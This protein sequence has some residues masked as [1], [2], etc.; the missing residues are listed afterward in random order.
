MAITPTDDALLPLVDRIY[1]SVDCPE[2][3][4]ETIAALGAVIGGRRDF[5]HADEGARPPAGLK[6]VEAGCH[7]TF[8]LSRQDLRV[9]DDYAQDFGQLIIR[10]LKVVFLSTLWSQKDVGAREAIGLKITERYLQTFGPTAA[11]VAS[12]AAGSAGRK[13]IAALWEDGRVFGSD[14]LRAMRLLIPH[15][16]RALRLQMRLNA[17]GLRSEMISGALDWL[18]LGVVL[19]D[20][21]GM[22]LWLNRRARQIMDGGHGLHVSAAGFA[23]RTPSDTRDLRA[24]IQ[25]VVSV[26]THGLLAIGRADLRPLLL[27][28]MPLNPIGPAG[29]RGTDP[30]TACGV[31]FLSDPDFENYPSATSLRQAFGLTGREAQA[32]IAIARGSGLKA[33]AESMGVA[34]TTARTLL[35]RVFAKTGTNH[36][37]ELAALVHRMLAPLRRD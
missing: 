7:G 14:S 36:Q 33:A 26:G 28:A 5:W 35:Q 4:P 25:G 24:L 23:G 18:A 16:D 19:L 6:G 21:A 1:E 22:P 20:R 12:P 31:V 32:A 17:A 30:E 10:F 13:L 3:W 8:F 34:Q 27:I 29:V 15:L 11:N 37:A 9:L 2:L